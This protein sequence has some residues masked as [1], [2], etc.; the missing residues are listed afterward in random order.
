MD[1]SIALTSGRP[2]FSPA[3]EDLITKVTNLM[4]AS[5]IQE[6]AAQETPELFSRSS[7][8]KVQSTIKKLGSDL[9]QRSTDALGKLYDNEVRSIVRQQNLNLLQSDTPLEQLDVE[10]EFAFVKLDLTTPSRLESISDNI[11]P[12]RSMTP[13][14]ATLTNTAVLNAPRLTLHPAIIRLIEDGRLNLPAQDVT[15]APVV[16]NKGLRFRVHEVK[17]LDE[18]NPEWP[19]KDEINMGGVAAGAGDQLKEIK[20]FRVGKFND[21]DRTRYSPPRTLHTYSLDVD[22]PAEFVFTTA[23]AEKDSGGLSKFI[24]DLYDA[25]DAHL[26]VI[27]SAVGAAAGA[28]AGSAIG[29]SL[30]TA[31]GGPLGLIIGAV[32]GAILGALVGWLI[33]VLKDDIFEPQAAAI[34]LPEKDSTFDGGSL[35][36]PVMSLNFRDHGG[37][38][39]VFYSWEIT[40]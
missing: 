20:E 3:I 19:G 33:N 12:V 32:A 37:H 6:L 11:F 16:V 8:S 18:T 22:Y 25:I 26:E 5:I 34:L 38:Y 4:K 24:S 15:P 40:R 35:T 14:A 39:R 2:E 27:L 7:S 36:S 1:Q 9:R 17:A 29:G 21:G 23:L 10:R 13:T 30:G 31:I 28:A